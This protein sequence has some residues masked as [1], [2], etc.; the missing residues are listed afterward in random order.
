MSARNWTVQGIAEL[1]SWILHRRHIWPSEHAAEDMIDEHIACGIR[2]IVW[3]L[4][5]SVLTYHSNLPNATCHGVGAHYDRFY[6]LADS[7]RKAE[8][9]VYHDRC[10]LRVAL[11]YCERRNCTVYGR[12]C[13]NRHYGPGSGQSVFAS[14]H[15]WWNEITGDGKL[16]VSRLCY[17]IP[18][19]RAERVAILKEA[20]EIGCAGLVLDF[21]R[22]PPMVRYHSALTHPY[23]E[24]TGIDPR[25]IRV[26]EHDRYLDWCRYRAGY[27]TELLRELK[28]ALDPLRAKHGVA[29]PVQARIPNDG[30]EANVIAGLDV[31]TWC[32]EGLITE[33]A[34]SELRWLPGYANW[35][36]RPYIALGHRHGIRVFGSSNCLPVQQKGWS[37]QVNPRGL[38][39][40]VLARRALRSLEQGADGLSLYQSDTGCYLPGVSDAISTFHDETS[41]RDYVDDGANTER[42][43][44]T[45]D[46]REYGID[47]HSD[48]LENLQR[49]VALGPEAA[50]V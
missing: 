33:I 9:Q 34:L 41:L 25:L 17:A 27:V 3:E 44:I 26:D 35:D 30:I 22:Q 39:P 5:R 42:Y 36:D 31:E 15:P 6:P 1:G 38:N 48:S 29:L 50:W 45:D 21:C 49:R 13:M 10:Q 43:P 23:R 18:E 47:N 16:D 14:E 24:R 20:A 7:Q 40:L 19:Y 2:H 46:N 8:M 11:T 28:A 32:S 4:G 37:G 12:L